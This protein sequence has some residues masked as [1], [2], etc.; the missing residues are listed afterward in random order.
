VK[1]FAVLA[2]CLASTANA[3]PTRN[4]ALTVFDPTPTTSGSLFQVLN[5]DVGGTGE[6]AASAI[7]TYASRPL[8]LTTDLGVLTVVK[9]HT[10]LLLGGAFA[11][12]DKYEAGVRVPIYMQSG[13]PVTPGEPGVE[14]A[15]GAALGDLTLHGK[16]R[17]VGAANGKVRAGA[18][19]ALSLPTA[20]LGGDGQ[21]AGTNLPT[22]RAV[23]L[24]T[25]APTRS[26]QLHLNAGGVL[27]ESSQF[28]NIEQGSGVT[29][30][31][32]VSWRIAEKLFLDAQAF[33]DLVP[34]SDYGRPTV[35]NPMGDAVMLKTMEA[36]V[37]GRFYVNQ[38]MSLGVG[39][40][41]G[42]SAGIGEPAWRGVISFAYTP[43]APALQ[44][45]HVA[46]PPEVI[47]PNTNDADYDKLV[48][49]KD[50][51]P[52]EGEDKDGFEDE[53]G[54]PE[55]DNDRDAVVDAKD[56]CP[57]VA[58]DKD[59]FADGDGCPDPDNDKDGVADGQDK[60]PDKPE[61]IN[62][63][64]DDD[65]CPDN[66]DALVISNPDRLEMLEPVLFK[67]DQV[68]PD[69][70][71]Q[72]NQLAATLRARAD[73]GRIRIGVHVQPSKA[74]AKKDQALSDR[75]A[76]AIREWL[77]KYGIAP[78]RIDVKGFGGSVPLV[79]PDSKGA[80]MINERVELIILERT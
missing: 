47:D 70:A 62:G 54:C 57:L 68:S 42:L 30:G 40:G 21:F 64:A 43:G 75:R 17:L 50:K 39:A 25:I 79:K 13:D 20:R 35:T 32:A 15:S 72:L 4:I 6:Y 60:C 46:P 66:G 22:V 2:L 9:H 3:E 71:N 7:A 59:G 38:Q 67:G 48:D 10:K 69:S 61:K 29:W 14:P 56:K 31:A 58:E 28:G 33:G 24:L 36:L 80:A 19:L 55:L 12:G 73:I 45:L 5:A 41:R 49:A 63:N 37:G 1:R 18:G 74:G 23:G 16:A 65:G 34:G 52:K 44:P 78:E 8:V 76:T 11:F 51:C 26:L 27:R 53:D 77:V